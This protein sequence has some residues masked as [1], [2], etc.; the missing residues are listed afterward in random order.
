MT[1]TPK[2]KIRGIPAPL[3]DHFWKQCEPFV[4][5]ALEHNTG[6][7]VATD[8]RDFCKERLAQLWVV[9]EGEKIVGVCTT[10]IVNYPQKRH[11]RIFTLAGTGREWFP[12]LDIIL[13]AWARENGC[14]A[15]EAIVRKG[16]VPILVNYGG[17]HKYSTVVKEL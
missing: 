6:E 4:K 14:Q 7:V 16:F 8:I 1:D 2:Y 10:E 5:R 12:E 17:K 13:C 3:V 15:I 9:I 11:C